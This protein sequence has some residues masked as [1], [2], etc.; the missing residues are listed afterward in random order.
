LR[1][2]APK[3]RE[4]AA[5]DEGKRA[6]EVVDYD[7]AT[8]EFVDELARIREDGVVSHLVSTRRAR[9]C[10]PVPHAGAAGDR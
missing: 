9:Q 2:H 6:L 4:K 3:G 10:R 8:E 5:S 1:R 7:E